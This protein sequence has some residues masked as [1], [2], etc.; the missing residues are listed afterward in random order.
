MSIAPTQDNTQDDQEVTDS[1]DNFSFSSLL[2]Q[3]TAQFTGNGTPPINTP[4]ISQIKKYVCQSIWS[5]KYVELRLLLPNSI[6]S[7]T[8]QA[9]T[10]QMDNN[11]NISMAPCN[12]TRKI[13]NINS[14]TSA[15]IRYMAVYAS[16]FPL[17]IPALL[18]YAEIVRDIA[19]RKPGQSFL[20]YDTQFRQARETSLLSW[21]RIHTEFWLMAC[22][23]FQQPSVISNRPFRTTQGR[24]SPQGRISQSQNASGRIHVGRTIDNPAA[25]IRNVASPTYAATAKAAT[26]RS[27]ANSPPK[28]KHHVQP[29]VHQPDSL[30]STKDQKPPTTPIKICKLSPFLVNYPLSDY[31]IL[32]VL[33]WVT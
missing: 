20:Y 2:G 18:K 19:S 13:H 3:H 9:Y 7:S 17:E 16:K 1:E 10:L 27:H 28:S 26:L 4:I 14:W 15:F 5:N 12:K 33:N 29:P 23:A 30:L 22:T 11:S 21:D 24:I 31:I 32:A 8:N 6:N 25:V